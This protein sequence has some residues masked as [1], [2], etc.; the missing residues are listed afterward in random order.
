MWSFS[1]DKN[2][3]PSKRKVAKI[4]VGNPC[5]NCPHSHLDHTMYFPQTCLIEGCTCSGLKLDLKPIEPKVER[6]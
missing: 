6:N 4:K 5:Q 1:K 3:D 2:L